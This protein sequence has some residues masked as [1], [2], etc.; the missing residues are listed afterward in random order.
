MITCGADERLLEGLEQNWPCLLQLAHDAA[1]ACPDQSQVR[2]A[3]EECMRCRT[4]D[5]LLPT[6]RKLAVQFGS[7]LVQVLTHSC[8]TSVLLWTCFA[9]LFMSLQHM[10][11]IDAELDKHVSCPLLPLATTCF[12]SL[13]ILMEFAYF[14][15]HP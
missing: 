4:L 8:Q 3:A 10:S 15:L 13:N 14:V 11:L 2:A 12:T 6:F 9:A 7:L 1:A 5:Q